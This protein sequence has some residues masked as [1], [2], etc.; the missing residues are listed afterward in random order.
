MPQIDK[1][2]EETGIKVNIE[3][4]P[5]SELQT[6]ATLML[7]QGS[8]QYDI[9]FNNANTT[10]A[11]VANN[12]LLALDEYLKDDRLNIYYDESDLIPGYLNLFKVDGKLYGLPVYGESSFL[13][14][15]KDVFDEYGLKV[16]ETFTELYECAKT[17]YERSGGKMYGIT[18]RGGVDRYNLDACS[19]FIWG[20]GGRWFDENDQLDLDSP[21]AIAGVEMFAKLVREYAP[22]GAANFGWQENRL[23][24]SNGLAA[25]TIDATVN[26]AYNEDPN[27]SKIVGLVGYAKMPVEVS[28]DKLYGNNAALVSHGLFIN[29]FVSEARKQAAVLFATWATSSEVQAEAQVVSPFCG[30]S[31]LSAMQSPA[32]KERYAPFI[33]AMVYSINNGNPGLSGANPKGNELRSLVSTAINQVIVGEKTA[34]EAMKEVTEKIN[35]TILKNG[36]N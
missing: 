19:P 34:E 5:F 20:F 11:N 31:S 17:I 2:Q 23:A 24:F 3:I 4:I 16:P 1:F 28:K 32:F 6:K 26:G 14:Y 33:D 15:R 22:P 9:M 21:E 35:S 13:M 36:F 7:S 18:L 12:Y 30:T 29:P 8:D 27:E 25:M 10:A